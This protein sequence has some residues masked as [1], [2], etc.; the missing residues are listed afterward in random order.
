MLTAILEEK[1]YP[2]KVLGVFGSNPVLTWSNSRRVVEALKAVD[3][4]VVTD[5]V[6][7]PTAALA[8]IVLPAASYLETD[9]VITAG[10][11]R[12]CYLEPQ[13]KV[14]Q[15]G[16][17]RSDL[18]II[19]GLA[20][21]LGLGDYFAPDL[22]GL[23]DQYLEP[24]G[25]SFA[26]LC[27]P[28]GVVSSSLRYRKHLDDGF[29]TPSG[30]VE[31]YSSL[32]EEWGFEPL[33]VYHEVDETPFSAPEMLVR[34]PLVL[35][36]GHEADY[37]HSQDRD[38]SRCFALAS[39]ASGHHPSRDGGGTRHRRGRS[40]VHREPAGT[41]HAAGHARRGDRSRGW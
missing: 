11:L 16:E 32:C 31:L 39:R 25:V 9:A 21:R 36:S 14:V 23:L 26:E 20:D 37:V 38:L 15:I 24:V 6:M 33:P 10:W 27:R 5:L 7:T 12:G 8:D 17:C 19:C 34:Y 35:T 1:P 4:L 41:D 2:V 40:G 22:D 28:P 29:D 3:F 18:E 30:K 13:Q